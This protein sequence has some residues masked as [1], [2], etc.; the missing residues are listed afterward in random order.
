MQSVVA[1]D[2]LQVQRGRD[3]P[4]RRRG[5]ADIGRV[6]C[7]GLRFMRPGDKRQP[8][9]RQPCKP[10]ACKRCVAASCR[11]GRPT[12][13]DR[14]V[15]RSLAPRTLI[16]PQVF[17]FAGREG[18]DLRNA[19]RAATGGAHGQ[20]EWIHHLG[21]HRALPLRRSLPALESGLSAPPPATRADGR[22]DPHHGRGVPAGLLKIDHSAKIARLPARPCC[23]RPRFPA[24]ACPCRGES[25]VPR[26]AP[27]G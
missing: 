24:R 2:S 14:H 16:R 19:G 3:F 8:F 6:P 23:L 26:R 25:R 17:G 12:P 10:R 27:A 5:S 4:G 11:V 9:K 18:L 20:Q 13:S 7:A 15:F 1:E 22:G 21:M